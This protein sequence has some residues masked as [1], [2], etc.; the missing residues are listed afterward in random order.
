MLPSLLLN[1][2]LCYQIMYGFMVLILMVGFIIGSLLVLDK[3]TSKNI[4]FYLLSSGTSKV[5]L[6][7]YFGMI[8]IFSIFVYTA[9]STLVNGLS[10]DIA[11]LGKAVGIVFFGMGVS[12]VG[13]GLQ[14]KDELFE[15]DSGD[16]DADDPTEKMA[17]YTQQSNFFL[18][19]FD[20]SDRSMELHLFLGAMA[21]LGVIFYEG[22]DIAYITKEF[23]P[24]DYGYSL[25]YAFVGIGAAGWGQGIQRKF[26][27]R[28]A[29]AVKKKAVRK[30]A[31]R[32]P[33]IPK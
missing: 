29:A 15:A 18:R 17:S 20:S 5:Q 31:P 1:S 32:K 27:N 19:L 2:K 3:K 25:A 4:V 26:A 21:L 16:P 10:L 11:S 28:E 9:F 22:Y 12:S 6:H 24:E 33:R 30:H 13:T 7:L 8:S 14:A 23:V